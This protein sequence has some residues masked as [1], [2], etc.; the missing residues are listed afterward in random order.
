MH[1]DRDRPYIVHDVDAATDFYFRHLGF[2]EVMHPA[3][4]LAMLGRGGLRVALGAP[5]PEA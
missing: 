5:A 4:T 3:P 2:A 1:D